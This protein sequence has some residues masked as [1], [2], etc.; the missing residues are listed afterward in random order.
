MASGKSDISAARFANEHEDK[1]CSCEYCLKTFTN[2]SMFFRHISHAKICSEHYGQ[3]FVNSMRT[4][5]RSNSKRKWLDAN[6]HNIKKSKPKK[7]YYVPNSIKNTTAGIRFQEIFREILKE[8]RVSARDKI[9]DYFN[10]KSN[11]ISNDI[12]EKALDKT[13]DFTSLSLFG[14][15][16][17]DITIVENEEDNLNLYFKKLEKLF[18]QNLENFTNEKASNWKMY[19]ELKIGNELLSFSMNKAFLSIYKEEQV[20]QIMEETENNALDEVLL[21][22]IVTKDYFKDDISD[23]SLE[24]HMNQSFL[25]AFKEQK[26]KVSEEK[27]LSLELREMMEEIMEK[28]VYVG[29]LECLI[30][31]TE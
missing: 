4:H 6:K 11:F 10:E 16:C 15:S 24:F 14:K 17:D 19:Q 25:A 7:S 27:G 3:E 21:K 29:E 20:N 5:L 31:K 9:N 13:F 1:S 8:F 23:S 12:V 30:A 2:V 18:D 28:R 22:L 26:M